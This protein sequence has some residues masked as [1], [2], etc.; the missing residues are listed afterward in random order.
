MVSRS[1][2]DLVIEF[3]YVNIDFFAA[4]FLHFESFQD[5]AKKKKR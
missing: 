2:I 3:I 1:D 4:P 5:W